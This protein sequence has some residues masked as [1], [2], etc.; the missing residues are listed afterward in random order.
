MLDALLSKAGLSHTDAAR[1]LKV[2]PRTLRR[3][4]Q[5]GRFPEAVRLALERR[6][7]LAPEAAEYLAEIGYWR[8]AA[9]GKRLARQGRA[10]TRPV[11]TL[12]RA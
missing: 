7:W 10:A 9:S 4:R 5:T 11:G 1:W 8:G 6:Q 3:Y 12:L 2:T